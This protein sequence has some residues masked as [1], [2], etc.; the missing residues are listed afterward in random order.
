M[1]DSTSSTDSKSSAGYIILDQPEQINRAA[2]LAAKGAMRLWMQG[3]KSNRFTPK[4]IRARFKL[5]S[6]TAAGLLKEIDELL[7]PPFCG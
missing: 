6:K 2:L 4:T 3:L 1:I 7:Y 5:N